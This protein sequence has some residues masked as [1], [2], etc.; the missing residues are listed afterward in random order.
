MSILSDI[1][2]TPDARDFWKG[3]SRKF[4]VQMIDMVTGDIRDID[5]AKLYS[6]NDPEKYRLFV[7]SYEFV[8]GG[9]QSAKHKKESKRMG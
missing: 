4:H 5:S 1:D 2:Q 3:A 6:I 9:R 8:T 7:E